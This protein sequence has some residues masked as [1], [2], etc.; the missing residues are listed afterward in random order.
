MKTLGII[1]EFNPFHNGHK[2]LLEKSIDL[3]GADLA[4]TIMSGDFVQR[5]E[6]AIIDKFRRAETAMAA[7]FDLVIEMPNFVSLQSASFFA[8]KNVEI[9]N[10]LG[11]DYLCFGIENISPEDFK[12][13]VNYILENGEKIEGQIKKYLDMGY[14]YTKASYL[15]LEKLVKE[16]YLTSNNI[17]AFEYVKAI[18]EIG[19][20]IDF[21]P[22]ERMSAKNSDVE[23]KHNTF[24]SS[25]AIRNHL[26]RKNIQN[27][28]PKES[29]KNL[30]DF[31]QDHKTYP[32][33]DDFYSLLRYKALIE[34]SPMVDI[35]CY[36]EGMENLLYKN[37]LTC[38]TF[39]EF[40]NKSTSTRFTASRIRRLSLNYLLENKTFFN[41]ISIDFIKIL[42]CKKKAMEY[43]SKLDIKKLI[44]KKDLETL[45]E[46]E[47]LIANSSLKASK[48]YRMNLGSQINYD[49]T[50][51]FIL[52]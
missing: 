10:K 41:D 13:K 9:L 32:D 14:S 49:F 50:R 7:G 26:G 12:N 52:K 29:F 33:L 21:V 42:T 34:E 31:Y 47:K 16:D 48:L 1:S 40:L 22:I 5:G 2:Y 20:D 19:A 38:K 44:S 30:T 28:L 37:L 18:R 25:T 35:L 23:I 27:L 36:E 6:P 11:I 46:D 45:S 24:A 8:Y 4:I 15:S 43:L 17:L 39:H 51:K 3:T